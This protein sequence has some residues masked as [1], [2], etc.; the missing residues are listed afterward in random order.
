MNVESASPSLARNRNFLAVIAAAGVLATV[1]GATAVVSGTRG[2]ETDAGARSAAVAAPVSEVW[3]D[4]VFT[5]PAKAPDG[6]A[7]RPVTGL[8]ATEIL[9]TAETSFEKASR[10]EIYDSVAKTGRV[11]AEMPEPAGIKGYYAQQVEVGSAHFVWWGSTPNDDDKW[12]DVWA[13]PRTGG[14]AIQLAEL[15]GEASEVERLGVVADEVVWSVR[16]GGIYRVPLTGGTPERV[17][18]GAGLH[19]LGWPWASDVSG[20]AASGQQKIVN[21]ETGTTTAVGTPASVRG[22]RC[23]EAWC[24]GYTREGML[25]QKPDG[26]GRHVAPGLRSLDQPAL[27]GGFLLAG[28][29]KTAD[30]SATV[31]YD[32]Q[33]RRVAKIGDLA[34]FGVGLSSSPTSVVYWDPSRRAVRTCGSAEGVVAPARPSKSSTGCVTRQQADGTQISVLNLAAV[35]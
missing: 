29:S 25:V 9:V 21:L 20:N 3:R 30:A 28:G 11:V 22:F 34:A 2:E 13:V 4:A 17:T 35:R 33:T 5:M 6:A 23:D 1:V 12:A 14:G 32:P 15:T 18:E 8:S 7:Y 10:L 27:A 16:S 19:L 24:S 31:V 26:S